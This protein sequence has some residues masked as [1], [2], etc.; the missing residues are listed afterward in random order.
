MC[1][2][3]VKNYDFSLPEREEEFSA[4]HFGKNFLQTWLLR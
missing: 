1:R 4:V 3:R 2:A